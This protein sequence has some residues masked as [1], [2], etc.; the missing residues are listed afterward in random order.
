VWNCNVADNGTDCAQE[1]P[2]DRGALT[3]MWGCAP[4]CPEAT[5]TRSWPEEPLQDALD[6]FP[7]QLAFYRSS[8]LTDSSELERWHTVVAEQQEFLETH[9]EMLIPCSGLDNQPMV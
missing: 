8:Q 9:L 6:C 1:F 3:K 5:A 4:T 2:S 7:S